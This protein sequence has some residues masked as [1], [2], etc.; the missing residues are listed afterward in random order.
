MECRFPFG[1]RHSLFDRCRFMVSDAMT[2]HCLSERGACGF[3]DLHRPFCRDQNRHL[4]D[5]VLG[6]QRCELDDLARRRGPSDM[7]VNDNGTAKTSHAAS[8]DARTPR[9]AD[10]TA[11]RPIHGLVGWRPLPTATQTRAHGVSRSSSAE[12]SSARTC[13]AQRTPTAL[14]SVVQFP[15]LWWCR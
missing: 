5:D 14:V 15:R 1:G 9:S 10:T 2:R 13:A 7:D 3:A 6:K 4:S 12:A 11:R 8:D